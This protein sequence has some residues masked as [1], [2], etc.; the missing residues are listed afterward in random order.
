M[1]DMRVQ[2]N[3]AEA[4]MAMGVGVPRA[5][6]AAGDG[7]VLPPQHGLAAAS[8][9]GGAAA[10][11]AQLAAGETCADLAAE[12]LQAYDAGGGGKAGGAGAAAT[13]AA[14]AHIALHREKDKV[15][16]RGRASCSA[17]AQPAARRRRGS[18]PCC[19]R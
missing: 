6:W 11:P 12:V 2:L 16:T 18:C 9:L 10:P 3:A 15:R 4:P 19:P 1:G 8:R 7:R 13:A 17:R 5:C 14:A